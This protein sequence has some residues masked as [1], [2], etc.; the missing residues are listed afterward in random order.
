MEDNKPE[1]QPSAEFL[2]RLL[3][4]HR[5]A[6]AFRDAQFEADQLE[7]VDTRYR[8]ALEARVAAPLPGRLPRV[9]AAITNP[10]RKA[11]ITSIDRVVFSFI[12][13]L[14]QLGFD[15]VETAFGD[16]DWF[17]LDRNGPEAGSARLRRQVSTRP[18]A[19]RAGDV[20][21]VLNLDVGLPPRSYARIAER[22]A[23]GMQVHVFVHDIFLLSRPEWFSNQEVMG[24]R[25][26]LARMLPLATKLIAN[27]QHTARQLIRWQRLSRPKGRTRLHRTPICAVALGCDALSEG[28]SDASFDEHSPEAGNFVLPPAGGPVFLTVAT[29]HARKGV[30]TVINAF[31]ALWRDG[32]DVRLVL[33]GRTVGK[34]IGEQIRKHPEFGRRLLFPGFLSDAQI[35]QVASVAEALIVPSREEGFGLPLAEAVALG[36]PV[37]ARDIPVFREIA[38]DQPFYFGIGPGRDLPSRMRAWLALPPER[39]RAHVPTQAAFTWAQASRQLAAA[40]TSDLALGEVEVALAEPAPP[41]PRAARRP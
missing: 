15:V 39:K 20:F 35:R 17:E 1:Q 29:L 4:L 22:R 38:G 36:L 27:S 21:L 10:G 40:M 12:A 11:P 18:I 8:E 9:Y 24:M 37:I 23:R 19:P 32:I 28:G 16:Q 26:W 14:R 3:E 6:L 2:S 33:S 34:S 30:D 31:A 41:A 13:G 7:T 25:A 5:R